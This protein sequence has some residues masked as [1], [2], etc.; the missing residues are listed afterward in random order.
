MY[1]G[2]VLIVDDEPLIRWSVRQALEQAGHTVVEAENVAAAATASAKHDF[3]LALVDLKLP[4]GTG[5]DA[6]KKI[7]ENQ[8]GVAI[9]IITAFSSVETAVEAMKLGAYDY[10]CKPF[11]IDEVVMTVNRA[12]EMVTMRR[13]I[14][15]MKNNMK[16]TNAVQNLVGNSEAMQTL[17]KL[18]LKIAHSEA[19][20]ILIQGESGVGKDV[21]ARA[22]HFESSR[23]Y[24]PFMNV[25]CTA[26][27]DTLLESELFGHEK[28]AFTD[29][30]G[31]KKGL[32][33]VADG[34]TVYLD[35]IGDMSV[36]LQA[37]LLR[38]LEEK[39]FR[40]VGGTVDVHVDV[41]I[42]AATNRNLEKAVHEG[43][44]REDLFYR[45]NII[46]IRIPPLRERPEDIPA[47][48]E[49]FMK[50]FSAQFKK[51]VKQISAEALEVLMNYRWPGNIREIRNAIERAV[52]LCEGESIQ[53][54]DLLLQQTAPET[55]G[56]FTLPPGGISIEEVEKSL[57]VQA[58]KRTHGDKTKAAKLLGITRDQM[59]YRV[60][61][62]GLDKKKAVDE[63]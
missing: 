3:H 22:I 32:L 39:T 34:G 59:N 9:I 63:V 45:L 29:A 14:S 38:F 58:L 62:F 35:E 31:Q 55:T 11:N 20:T 7:Q 8:Q 6:M 53:A 46:P 12:I 16:A 47:L 25:T 60:K 18:V 26:L 17:K 43:K 2:S 15:A 13:D 33:E 42:I 61:K 51:N 40:R 5:I 4:D 49:F 27:Q 50:L 54:G 48:A 37:K 10:L 23:A 19:R 21:V 28:G 44:F 56:N 52:L 24:K 36:N 41:R 30:K 57:V 1:R